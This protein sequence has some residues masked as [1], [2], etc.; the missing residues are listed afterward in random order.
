LT[1]RTLLG[2]AILRR[3]AEFDQADL[4]AARPQFDAA[5]QKIKAPST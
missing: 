3:L 2:I 5:V 1:A 4:N